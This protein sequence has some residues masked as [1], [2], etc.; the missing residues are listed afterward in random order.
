M[1]LEIVQQT[2]WLVLQCYSLIY[3]S[4][5]FHHGSRETKREKALQQ[6]CPFHS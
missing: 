4:S 5:V 6:P 1:L 3:S 2:R